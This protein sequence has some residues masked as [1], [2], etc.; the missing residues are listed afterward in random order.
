MPIN[1]PLESMATRV[2]SSIM[3]QVRILL[4]DPRTGKMRYK[5]L[6]NLITGLLT[7]WLEDKKKGLDSITVEEAPADRFDAFDNRGE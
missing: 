2:P 6:S 5:S 7:K 1:D 3:L 4:L